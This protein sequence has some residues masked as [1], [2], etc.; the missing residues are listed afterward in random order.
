[1][2]TAQAA[3]N[4]PPMVSIVHANKC[5]GF[6]MARGPAGIEAFTRDESSLGLFADERAA[7]IAIFSHLDRNKVTM[8][9]LKGDAP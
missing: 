7:L 1:M 5:V 2:K 4:K 6:V 3:N 9:H 8:Q